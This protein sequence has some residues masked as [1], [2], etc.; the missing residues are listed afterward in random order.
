MRELGLVVTFNDVNIANVEKVLDEDGNPQE[1]F[2]EGPVE[3]AWEELVWM[4]TTLRWGRENL[5]SKF[6]EEIT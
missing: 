6:H 2:H 4:A 5:A 3:S 1:T